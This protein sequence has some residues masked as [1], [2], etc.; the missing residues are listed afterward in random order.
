MKQISAIVCLLLITM[1]AMVACTQSSSPAGNSADWTRPDNYYKANPS[2]DMFV[3]E[4]TTC[5]NAENNAWV[6]KLDLVLDREVG[7]IK[8]TGV[9]RD[10]QDFDATTLPIGAAVYTVHER[11]DILLVHIGNRDIPYLKVVEG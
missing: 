3:Y 8:R 5:E 4:G 9:T 1:F 10:F 11:G 2:I 7:T 6:S